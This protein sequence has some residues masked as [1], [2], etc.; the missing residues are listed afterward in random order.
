[1]IAIEKRAFTLSQ[2]DHG[3]NIV[4]ASE[5]YKKENHEFMKNTSSFATFNSPITLQIN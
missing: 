5:E 1:M 2:S 3:T 4:A